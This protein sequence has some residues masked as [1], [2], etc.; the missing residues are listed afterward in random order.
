VRVEPGCYHYRSWHPFF[1]ANLAAA[2]T[3]A[4][5]ALGVRRRL[6]AMQAPRAAGDSAQHIRTAKITVRR[7][8]GRTRNLA[9]ATRAIGG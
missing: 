3:D 2:S 1:E 8:L 9:G 4:D 6:P 5:L 7:N